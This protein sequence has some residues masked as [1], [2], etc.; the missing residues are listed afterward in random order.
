MASST[1]SP[2]TARVTVERNSPRDVKLRQVHVFLD[3]KQV[4]TLDYGSVIELHVEPGLH[5]IR[6][7]NTL[8]SRSLESEA[9]HGE[10][11]EFVVGNRAGGCLLALGATF[12]IGVLRV[13]LERSDG[14]RRTQRTV[15]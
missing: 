3:G 4:G 5:S 12:G 14:H 11:L 9:A 10:N 15:S 13:F 7:Y 8:M 1:E 2:G 6:A